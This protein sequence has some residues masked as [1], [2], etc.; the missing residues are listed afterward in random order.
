MSMGFLSNDE[1]KAI[2]E[3]IRKA[4]MMTS[5]E[6][7]VHVKPNCG[8][9]PL[10]DAKKFFTRLKMH[11]TKER[12]GVLIFVSPNRRRFAILGDKGIHEAVGQDYWNTTKDLMQRYFNEGKFAEGIIL[13]VENVGKRLAEHFPYQSSDRN[14]LSNEVTE[15]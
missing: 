9:D 12:N 6:I 1:K 4:E 15:G 7:R 14:E 10:A 11:R 13:G 2:A 8:E 5:G 3:A